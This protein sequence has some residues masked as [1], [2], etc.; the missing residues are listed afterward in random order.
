MNRKTTRSFSQR[1]LDR[2]L[3]QFEATFSVCLDT[4][5]S[6]K[7]GTPEAEGLHRFQPRLFNALLTLSRTY[8]DVR[9]E[10]RTL[11]GRKHQMRRAAYAKHLARLD[12][13]ATIL[14][15]A[16]GI[17]RNV[18]DAFLW[19]FYR[20]DPE[21][22]RRHRQQPSPSLPPPG[23][24]GEG[25]LALIDAVRF[26]EK[27]F[28]LFH[29]ITTMFRLG[30]ASLLDLDAQRIVGIGELKTTRIDAKRLNLHFVASFGPDT[31]MLEASTASVDS[32]PP[33]DSKRQARLNKQLAA[34]SRG[35]AA[36]ER[37]PIAK[38][39]LQ[40]SRMAH[41]E[42]LNSI[43][44]EVSPGRAVIRQLTP[45]LLAV[46][47][48]SRRRTVASRLQRASFELPR[49][50]KDEFADMAKRLMV[51][52]SPHNCIIIGNVFYGDNWQPFL[53]P[54]A[55]PML[56][57]PADSSTLRAMATGSV[58]VMTL[59]NPAH[60]L[61]DLVRNG[62]SVAR[63]E[64]P[65]HLALQFQHRGRV[66]TLEQAESFMQ[67]VY[68]S[69]YSEEYAIRVISETFEKLKD[70]PVD[71]APRIDLTISHHVFF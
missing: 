45:G 38:M 34:I 24:G 8:H 54:G 53:V 12:R 16:I 23:D 43:V 30:D 67:L 44:A 33:L 55:T 62:Y 4:V 15:Q 11:I 37:P 3:R 71:G 68:T 18:G 59:F 51:A 46:A 29:G 21:L 6:I 39:E 28:I 14:L 42:E 27:R 17:G 50:A 32:F 10:R 22:L 58:K 64:P 9:R 40:A 66:L 56:L 25:E 7:D 57:W 35:A 52:D 1:S 36:A 47:I 19:F 41:V 63:F 20:N 2:E 5:L 49:S 60:M 69:L 31:V 48:A 13:W 65:K 70:H 26:L 61:S